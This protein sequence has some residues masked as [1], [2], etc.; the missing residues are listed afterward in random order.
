[1]DAWADMMAYNDQDV[2]LLEQVYLKL[3]PWAKTHP[4]YGLYVDD[5]NPRCIR[6]GHDKLWRQGFAYTNLGKFQ[7]YQCTK[8]GCMSWMRGRKNVKSRDSL[9]ANAL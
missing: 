8:E 4:S 9:L 2:L 7:A 1:M 3:R 5:D 6:C